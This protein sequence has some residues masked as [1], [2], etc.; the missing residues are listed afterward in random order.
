MTQIMWYDNG[1]GYTLES[2]SRTYTIDDMTGLLKDF[3]NST[4]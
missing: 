4:K 1:I 2:I 3:I